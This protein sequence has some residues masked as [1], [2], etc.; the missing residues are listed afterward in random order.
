VAGAYL[1]ARDIDEARLLKVRTSLRYDISPED[2]EK[3]LR[4]PLRHF[5]EKNKLRDKVRCVVLTWGIPVRVTATKG[6]KK[7]DASVDSELALCWHDKYAR[8]E[9]LRN[10]LHWRMSGRVRKD[11]PP[12]L[13]TARIDGPT[14][15]D[16]LK[17]IKY[18]MSAESQGME[19]RLYVDA[20]GKYPQYDRYLK[21]LHAWTRK[22]AKLGSVLDTDPKLFRVGSCRKAALYVGWYSL[23]KYV[24]SCMWSLGAVGWHIS[25]FEAQDLRDPGSNHWCVKMIQNGVAATVGAVNEP[26]LHTFPRPDEFFPML[27]TGKYTLAECYWRTAPAASWRLTLIGDPLYNP[28]RKNPQAKVED[29]PKGLAP[30]EARADAEAKAAR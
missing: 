6:Q 16:A 4:G 20:G 24:A 25:S 3:Q 12:T 8:K 21:Q 15:A 28:F 7:S 22:H 23:R 19:G 27:M 11:A 13:M 10:A 26:Y 9:A 29:L 1:K 18:T 14:A 2:Y 17:M 5:L 30:P